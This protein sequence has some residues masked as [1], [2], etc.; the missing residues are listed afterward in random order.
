MLL[1]QIILKNFRNFGD[2]KFNFNPFLTIIIG[3]NAKGKTN[4]LEGIF[5]I[6][7]GEG[8]R[9][10][11][12]EELIRFEQ[13]QSDVQGIFASGDEDFLFQIGIKKSGRGVD[14]IFSLNKSR[15]KYFQYQRETAKA[16]LFSPEQIEIMN[17]PPE[18]RRRYFD[19]LLGSFDLV[20]KKKLRNYE[21][22]LRRRN[23]ILQTYKNEA[24]LL[25]EL[26]FWNTYLEENAGYLVQKRQDYIDFLNEHNKINS[27]EFSIEYLKSEL[28]KK[29][30]EENFELEKRYRR[31]VI[32]PQKDDFQLSQKDE[33]LKNLHHF[34]SRSEQ[35][36]G[37][38][39]LKL[40]EI[41]F[42]EEAFKTKP[43]LLLD[44]IFSELDVKNK[45]LVIDLVKKYQTV[46]TTTEIELLELADV[47]KSIIKL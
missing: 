18:K 7:Y 39:W 1:K 29:R 27:K 10:S 33:S 5:L 35:R 19:T 25:E 20:Y 34:G 28:N 22:A 26:K 8:F 13:D 2:E 16:I 43:L 44:D 37:V 21:N 17:G 9:E 3:E 12:E 40:N 6:V 15:R 30:L 11:K 31:T 24:D 45:K 36:L 47:P 42:L 38:F 23:K 46:V 14:K 41:K 4:L 32:G